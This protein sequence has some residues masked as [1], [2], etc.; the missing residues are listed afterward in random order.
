[1]VMTVVPASLGFVDET[2]RKDRHCA[3]TDQ[4]LLH[5]QKNLPEN[6]RNCRASYI[7]ARARFVSV[8]RRPG[9]ARGKSGPDAA[10]PSRI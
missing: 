7:K 1:M 8:L 9:L 5:H 10:A 6:G 4:D 3:Q 2:E